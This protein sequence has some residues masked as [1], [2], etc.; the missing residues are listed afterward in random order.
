[1]SNIT[2]DELIERDRIKITSKYVDTRE[3]DTGWTHHAYRVT[4]RRKGRQ[5]TL[6][7]RM[8]TGHTSDPELRDVLHSVLSDTSGYLNASG[9]C[10]WAEEYGYDTDSIRALNTYNAVKAQSNRL[11]KFLRDTSTFLEYVREANWQI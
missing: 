8:S 6:D 9:F 3:D 11:E 10:D 4:L 5:W 1:M 7:Y 2:L